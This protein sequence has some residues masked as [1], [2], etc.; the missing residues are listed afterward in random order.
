MQRAMQIAT[1]ENSHGH[2]L[3]RLALLRYARYANPRKDV[4]NITHVLNYDYPNNSEDYVHRIGRT[5]RA[6]A[7][8]T[9]I[10]LFTTDSKLSF[11]NADSYEYEL[12]QRMTD[13]KQ[14]SYRIGYS[15]RLTTFADDDCRLA[16]LLLFLPNLNN[17]L[18]HAWPRW[19]ATLEVEAVADTEAAAVVVVEGVVVDSTTR[20]RRL[21]VATAAGKRNSVLPYSCMLRNERITVDRQI[22]YIPF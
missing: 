4:K 2:H 8:G 11:L 12:I 22:H 21:W 19:L 6:G 18:T 15:K 1:T 10:T 7:V 16:I 17:K 5:G 20:T 14:V 3:A 9:A 13:A